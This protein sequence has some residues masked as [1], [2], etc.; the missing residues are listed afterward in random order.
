MTKP[1]WIGALG[2][3]LVGSASAGAQEAPP[4]AAPVA[5]APESWL[6]GLIEQR[7]DTQGRSCE[8]QSLASSGE[9]RYLACGEAGVWVVKLPPGRAP[10]VIEQRPT[11]G[12]ASGFFLRDGTLWVETTSVQAAR[13]VPVEADAQIVPDPLATQGKPPAPNPPPLAAAAVAP[14]AQAAPGAPRTG[15]MS[16]DEDYEPAEANVVSLDPGFAIID[17]GREHGVASGD[18]VAFERVV[19]DRVDDDN[20]AQRRERLAVGMA[21]AIGESRTRVE[22]G[23]GERVDIG[24]FA[25]PTREPVSARPFAPARLG[26]VWHVGFF[27]RPFLIVD[28]FGF[29]TSFEARAGYRF[30]VPFHLEAMVVPFTVATGREGAVVAATGLVVASFDS[31]FFELG[32][33]LGGQTVNDPA[34]DL[35]AGTGTT[36]AQRLRIG[37][38]DGGNIEVMTYVTLFHS[39]FEFAD[40]NIHAQLPVGDRSWLIANAGGGTGGMGFGELGL[41]VLL[42]GNGDAG[43]FLISATIGGVHVFESGFCEEEFRN[44]TEVD[45]TGPMAG[46]GSEWRF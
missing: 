32:L 44:C 43:S 10:E 28:N 5:K 25:H 26:G 29:G 45:Y 27:V 36:I 31:K 11:P 2:L 39:E 7:R 6:P 38:A 22:L 42:S 21:V 19:K 15:E 46:F 18:H 33:G 4:A 34:F 3:F 9:L 30:D 14:V 20:A 40:I 17:M 8:L 24:A 16:A 41:R 35:E 37:S 1:A 13:L 12:V 23:V